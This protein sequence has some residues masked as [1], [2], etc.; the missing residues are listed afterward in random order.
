MAPERGGT[1]PGIQEQGRQLDGVD[2][3]VA[4]QDGG[5]GV[6]RKEGDKDGDEEDS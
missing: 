2:G 3:R 5:V 4:E 6:G 1:S